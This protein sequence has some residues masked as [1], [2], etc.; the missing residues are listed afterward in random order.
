M[1]ASDVR[2][3]IAGFEAAAAVDRETQRLL[4][5]GAQDPIRLSLSMIDVVRRTGGRRLR[6]AARDRDEE[7][8][9]A[10]WARLRERLG[11]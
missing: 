3:W 9:R 2:R 6:D 1:N 10:T 4:N 8:V 11:S 7:Q 5:A